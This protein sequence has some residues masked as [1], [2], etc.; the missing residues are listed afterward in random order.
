[1]CCCTMSDESWESPRPWTYGPVLLLFLYVMTYVKSQ[2]MQPMDGEGGASCI[3]IGGGC[4][5]V[6]MQG[7][8]ERQVALFL[9]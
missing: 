6:V 9:P 1:M 4:Q 8:G 7:K 5:I 3:A 2:D